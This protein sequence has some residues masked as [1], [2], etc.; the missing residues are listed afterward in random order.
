MLYNDG[1]FGIAMI[2]NTNAGIDPPARI[3]LDVGRGCL[4][5]ATTDREE[6]HLDTNY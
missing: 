5:S 4:H 2:L 3:I 6:V 1:V